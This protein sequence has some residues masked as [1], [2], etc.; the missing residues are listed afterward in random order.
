MNP[1]LAKNLMSQFRENA[2]TDAQTDIPIKINF[3]KNIKMKKA[4]VCQLCMEEVKKTLV[5]QLCMEEG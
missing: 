3:M 2:Q 5:C 4:L 1:E